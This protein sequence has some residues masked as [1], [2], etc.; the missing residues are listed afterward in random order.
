MDPVANAKRQLQ[1]TVD[2]I[3]LAE[4]RTSPRGRVMED[5]AIELAELV[6]AQ[7]EWRSKGG[8]DPYRQNPTEMG[9][10]GSQS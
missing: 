9:I 8:F 4:R 1:L 6:A 5:M 3:S 7:H 2:I 10:R